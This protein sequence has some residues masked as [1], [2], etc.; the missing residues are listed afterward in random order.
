MVV[1]SSISIVCWIR[2][3][4]KKEKNLRTK[5][6]EKRR[7][8]KTSAILGD[9]L[10]PGLLKQNPW[11]KSKN[12]SLVGGPFK[13]EFAILDGKVKRCLK[14][15]MTQLCGVSPAG[16]LHSVI[17]ERGRERER[18]RERFGPYWRRVHALSTT[19]WF[20]NHLWKGNV[21]T[22]SVKAKPFY[23]IDKSVS[24]WG[25]L[26]PEMFHV[27]ILVCLTDGKGQGCL[28]HVPTK[29]WNLNRRQEAE[30]IWT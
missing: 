7:N 16:R 2:F 14:P 6:N 17:K 11:M 22:R 26:T 10:A 12:K 5:I 19:K 9:F 25:S 1:P 21:N 8:W 20:L 30:N 3:N 24:I 18:E 4:T 28:R 27:G 29:F 23:K 15:V 13:P